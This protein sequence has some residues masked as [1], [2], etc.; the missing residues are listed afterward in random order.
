LFTALLILF[1]LLNFFPKSTFPNL[2]SRLS[3]SPATLSLS[4]LCAG[5]HRRLSLSGDALCFLCSGDTIC[6][7]L[8]RLSS[9]KLEQQLKEVGSKLETP[10]STKDALVKLLKVLYLHFSFFF[11][12]LRLCSVWLLRKFQERKLRI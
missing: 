3:L 7:S 8:L 1:L 11:F 5:S 9:K 12:E 6:R 10:P 4:V 2:L